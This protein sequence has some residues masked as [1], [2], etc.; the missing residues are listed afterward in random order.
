VSLRVHF[1]LVH[2]FST[3]NK[4]SC[5]SLPRLHK[6]HTS[7]C[8][9]EKV[10]SAPSKSFANEVLGTRSTRRSTREEERFCR[11]TIATSALPT[12]HSFLVSR[13]SFLV[14]RFSF[15]VSRFS[16][17]FSSFSILVS[18]FSFL[19]SR[20]SFLV[21]R[22]SFLDSRFSLPSLCHVV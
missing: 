17:L 14:S 10:L 6:M 3:L 22:F 13:F 4:K 1:F 15:L 19:V 2:V 20:F 11:V 21:S 8:G 16:F 5:E 7:C 9:A 18:R 12:Q